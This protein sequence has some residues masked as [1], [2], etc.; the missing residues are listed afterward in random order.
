MEPIYEH[1]I[2]VRFKASTTSGLP[3]K[4][5]P[6]QESIIGNVIDHSNSI[7]DVQWRK[8][9]EPIS[10]RHFQYILYYRSPSILKLDF[11]KLGL[12]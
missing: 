3:W 2:V 10:D 1:P 4:F 5:T 6:C 12:R 9:R 7:I 8:I 11:S